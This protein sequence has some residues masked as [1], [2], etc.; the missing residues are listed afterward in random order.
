MT[1]DILVLRSQHVK[2]LWRSTTMCRFWPSSA[3]G[4]C[5]LLPS[6]MAAAAVLA[7]VVA[8]AAVV[9]AVFFGGIGQGVAGACWTGERLPGL[10]DHPPSNPADVVAEVAGVA[11]CLHA[12]AWHRCGPPTSGVTPMWLDLVWL[13]STGTFACDIAAVSCHHERLIRRC[14]TAALQ[15]QS[16]PFCQ[17]NTSYVTS[18]FPHICKKRKF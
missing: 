6:M 15:Q 10:P 12:P 7:A 3:R 14:C 13:C 18:N 8:V 5:L 16:L 11:V 1:S 9:A 17:P 4:S 2:L